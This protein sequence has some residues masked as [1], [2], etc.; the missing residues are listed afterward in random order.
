MSILATF[1]EPKI[2]TRCPK[3]TLGTHEIYRVPGGKTFCVHC[4]KVFVPIA[5]GK[6][7][8][9]EDENVCR[10]INDTMSCDAEGNVFCSECEQKF[11]ED[12]SLSAHG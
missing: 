2:D 12:G 5:D 1:P 11:R 6:E 8:L 9:D 7:Y 10:H 4:A 3:H